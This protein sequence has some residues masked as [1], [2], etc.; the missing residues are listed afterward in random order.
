MDTRLTAVFKT[1]VA[2]PGREPDESIL[3]FHTVQVLAD[4][5]IKIK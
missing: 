3:V 1:L 4:T 2:E 5:M